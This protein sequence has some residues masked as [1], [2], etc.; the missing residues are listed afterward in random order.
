MASSLLAAAELPVDAP[1]T[2]QVRT[3]AELE[4]PLR[5][6]GFGRLEWR[7]RPDSDERV[8]IGWE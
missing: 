8:V 5:N 7:S 3:Q 1:L 6:A 2:G 4:A